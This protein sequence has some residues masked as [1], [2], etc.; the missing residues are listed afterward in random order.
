MPLNS[1]EDTNVTI[2]SKSAKPWR[3]KSSAAAPASSGCRGAQ[4]QVPQ[5]API[6]NPG[7][8]V[9]IVPL[10]SSSAGVAAAGGEAEEPVDI[11]SMMA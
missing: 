6:R 3:C 5:R 10:S 8:L 7:P 2:S 9:Q 1:E 4:G 11:A